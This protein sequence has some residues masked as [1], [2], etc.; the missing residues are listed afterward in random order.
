MK[1]DENAEIGVVL[2]LGATQDQ[3]QHSHSIEYI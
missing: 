2:G 1:V 3:R